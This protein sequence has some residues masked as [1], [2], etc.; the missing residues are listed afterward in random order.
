MNAEL[1]NLITTLEKSVQVLQ[2]KEV[3]EE[4]RSSLLANSEGELP[5]TETLAK[6]RKISGL[7]GELTQLIE[8]A[9]TILAD[10][11]LGK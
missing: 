8:P 5:S 7:V 1:N 10:H 9:H 4:L 11:F 6:A 3:Y 2:S